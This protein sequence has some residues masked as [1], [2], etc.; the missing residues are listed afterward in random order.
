MAMVHSFIYH[1]TFVYIYD[2]RLGLLLETLDILVKRKSGADQLYDYL[3]RSWIVDRNR[4]HKRLH[5]II[6]FQS[7][8][9]K[10]CRIVCSSRKY[11][12]MLLSLST[13]N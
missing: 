8:H 11:R 3:A 5:S 7:V 13:I 12:T 9:V 2:S 1:G 10:L 6:G 4:G